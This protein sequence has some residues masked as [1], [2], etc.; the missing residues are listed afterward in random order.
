MWKYLL[1]NWKEKKSKCIL[2]I[3][4]LNTNF[5]IIR[6]KIHKPIDELP[7]VCSGDLP[8]ELIGE[9]DM[10]I[11]LTKG[12]VLVNFNIIIIIYQLLILFFIVFSKRMDTSC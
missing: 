2:D 3:I 9:P 10:E 5:I 11:T 6:W 1:F 8:L 12:D 4:L 7:N